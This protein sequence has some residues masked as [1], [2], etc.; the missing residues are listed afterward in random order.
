M[1]H[2]VVIA[3]GSG[4]R[5]WPMSR[6]KLPKQLLP[7]VGGRSLL[8]VSIDRL[9]GIIPD[10]NQYVCAAEAHRHMVVKSLDNFD[11]EQFLG[12]PVGRDTLNAVGYACA[13]IAKRDKDATIAIFTADHI[14]E[15]VD[16]FREI[17]AQG[18]TLAESAD[19]RLVTFGITP[20][21]PATGYGYLE[22][23]DPLDTALANKVSK[24]KEKP[25]L[26]TAEQYLAAGPS[27]YLWS[28]GMFVWKAST[29]LACIEKFAPENYPGL[30]RIASKYDSRQRYTIIDE[31]YPTL[32]KI[33]VDY[34][35]M[36]PASKDEQFEVCAVPMD[37]SWTDIGSWP[38]FA[39]T[40]QVDQNNN[41]VAAEKNILIDSKN[42]LVASQ[43]KD[44]LITTV[45]CEN[46][47]IIHTPDATMICHADRVQE[48]KDLH[49]KVKDQHGEDYL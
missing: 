45:G 47:V 12:E 25:D 26:Q 15:P 39:K 8:Q 37:L 1:R 49:K 44:H 7:Y 48:I 29:L 27:K 16:K 34:A 28:S 11:D 3:G 35:I 40:W 14:I 23:G 2:A 41:A 38:E 6:A 22:L 24:Y 21:N 31:V 18:Y 17:V 20:T 5:L 42:L 33:S 43:D 19:N 36:E 13:V 46:L 10:E 9:K 30:L 32:K 4:T